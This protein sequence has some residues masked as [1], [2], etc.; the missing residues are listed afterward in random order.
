VT[1]G[2]V[3]GTHEV[4]SQ[5]QCWG[6]VPPTGAS[7]LTAIGSR[8]FFSV[9]D[10]YGF[11]P[12]EAVWW[13]SGDTVTHLVEPVP[14]EP[15]R[16]PQFATEFVPAGGEI[17]FSG[18][19]FTDGTAQGTST[20]APQ[21]TPLFWDAE[22]ITAFP[23]GILFTTG[24]PRSTRSH[25]ELWRAS[26]S[27]HSAQEV[28]AVG[29][30]SEE[31]NPSDITDLGG[32]AL[33]YGNDDEEQRGLWATNGTTAQRVSDKPRAQANFEVNC[34]E[35][36]LAIGDRALF[37]APGGGLWM[38]DGQPGNAQPLAHPGDEGYCPVELLAIP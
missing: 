28:S 17:F 24:K 12:A 15:L 2:T 32:E 19:D 38:T 26:P 23:G 14:A 21:K 34:A 31:L 13:L 18:P 5:K 27:P 6:C 16:W 35:D 29:A 7:A 11:G 9:Q 10:V 8:V 25:G 20:V 36:I 22:D 3:S 30:M 33:F 1:N 37:A 4:W